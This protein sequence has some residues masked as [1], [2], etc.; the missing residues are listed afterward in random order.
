ME[1]DHEGL[2]PEQLALKAVQHVNDCFLSIGNC[3]AQRAFAGSWREPTAE[4]SPDFTPPSGRVKVNLRGRKAFF[5]RRASRRRSAAPTARLRRAFAG[6]WREP[7][8]E[9][10]P[11]FTPPSGRVKVNLR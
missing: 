3:Y 6:F 11:D 9:K 5:A 2:T 10:S 7:T 8:A 4:K 1:I